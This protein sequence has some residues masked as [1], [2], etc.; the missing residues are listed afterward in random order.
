MKNL[1]YLLTLF[2]IL[3]SCSES[4]GPTPPNT[5]ETPEAIEQGAQ[6]FSI[7]NKEITAKN[8]S[9]LTAKEYIP[10]YVF[11][12]V[13]TENGN[14]IFDR[15]RLTVIANDDDYV[16][17]EIMLD[18]GTYTLT[19]FIVVD[20]DDLVISLV[21]KATSALSQFTGTSLPFDFTVQEADSKNTTIE[22]IDAAG[23]SWVAFG[24]EEDDLVFPDAESF[25]MLT[26]DDTEHLTTKTIE[27]KSLTGS[28]Y[29]I[30]WGDGTED[31]YVSTLSGMDINNAL[32]HDYE[33]QGV[34]E[35]KIFGAVEVIEYLS[36][37]NS[38]QEQNLQTNITSAE[39]DKLILLKTC[40]FYAGALTSLDTSNNSALEKLSVG[41]N[42]IT[43]LNLSNNVNLKTLWARHN[44]L[45]QIDVSE[46][47]DLESL[48]ISG[49]QI[50]TLDISNNAMLKSLLAS[51]N[52][53]TSFDFTNNSALESID[54]SDNSLTNIDV[55]QNLNLRQIRVGRNNLTGVDLSNN[56]ELGSL[57]LYGNQITAIDL[58]ANIKLRELYMEN[59][60]LTDLDLSK[61]VELIT[62]DIENNNF[63]QI[64][65]TQ[66][67]NIFV[68]EVGGN[69][70][71]APELDQMISFIYDQAVL[72]STT[73][74]YI[75]FKNNPGTD[76]I[77]QTTIAKINE[78]ALDYQWTFNN[79]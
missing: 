66:N 72:N 61:N 67:P 18:P 27:I 52:N 56:S 42:Q 37:N 68:L 62:L 46:N 75:D 59:N 17:E 21:P 74:G 19:E 55:S 14:K 51:E 69:Q 32:S 44:Q 53:F 8:P 73:L 40:E 48:S 31:E 20:S 64:D 50:S 9:G 13:E 1:I 11:V 60:L 41:Y 16:T 57:E 65:I 76:S 58:T 12:S 78:L 2:T 38:D 25:F 30:D 4:E 7:G 36:F 28:T 3:I 79:N 23:Y 22:N 10:A 34:Y 70:F 15:Q 29:R 49:N 63:S 54:L 26:V 71:L 5:P 39:I 33:E 47:A 35:I 43:N 45:T 77:D 6:S 24:Y